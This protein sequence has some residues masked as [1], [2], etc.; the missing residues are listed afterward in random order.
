MAVGYVFI[1]PPVFAQGPPSLDV[2]R[3]EPTERVAMVKF[4]CGTSTG[5]ELAPGRY[6]TAINIA[7]LGGRRAQPVDLR[8]DVIRTNGVRGTAESVVVGTIGGAQGLEVDCALLA[9]LFKSDL[10]TD[11]LKGFVRFFGNS[12]EFGDRMNRLEF[13]AV[14][15]AMPAPQ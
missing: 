11:L 6:F 2:V 3:I 8:M 5:G 7:H 1:A 12:F 14:Y 15:S 9:A 4:I 10:G 13:V